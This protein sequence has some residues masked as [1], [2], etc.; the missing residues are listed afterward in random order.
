MSR[1]VVFTNGCFD[2]LH[3]G[4]IEYLQQA[5]NFGDCL[6]IGLNSDSSV[7]KLKGEFRPINNQ[8]DRR[9]MLL[10]LRSVDR[11]II[12]DEETPYNLIKELKPDIL[13]K[14][15]DY[16]VEDIIGHDIVESYGGRV[17]SLSFKEGYSTTNLVNK[18]Q[19]K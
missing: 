10:E 19:G 17:L 12:F 8:E 15:G 14:G 2:I 1:K 6:I 13:V 18:V 4:H 16:K 9:K 5:R 11:V 7:K 3:V